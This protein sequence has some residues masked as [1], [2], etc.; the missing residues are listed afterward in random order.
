MLENEIKIIDQEM[1]EAVDAVRLGWE[2]DAPDQEYA[3]SANALLNFLADLDQ[4][5]RDVAI[6]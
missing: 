1:F 6:K 5:N 2:P 3:Q 4:F